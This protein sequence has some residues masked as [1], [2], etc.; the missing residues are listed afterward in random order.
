MTQPRRPAAGRRPAA[1]RGRAGRTPRTVAAQ[2]VSPEPASARVGNPFTGRAA[3]L[4]LVVCTLVFS[5]ALPVREYVQQRSEISR[6]E[7]EQAARQERV[8]ALEAAK[9]QMQ[10]PAH[11]AAEAR[12]RL[13]MALPGEVAYVLITP[14]PVPVD[15]AAS[16]GSSADDPWYGQVW[17]SVESADRPGAEEPVELPVPVPVP[18]PAAP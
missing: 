16:A 11:I 12:R 2:G 6:L 17:S 3:L 4:G 15:E 9:K 18:E 8:E 10:D 7:A 14:E 13:H 1:S 5:A